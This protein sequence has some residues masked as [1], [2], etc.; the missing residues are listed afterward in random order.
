MQCTNFMCQFKKLV[1]KGLQELVSP[2]PAFACQAVT[3]QV[4]KSY[5]YP[6]NA[7]IIVY[8]WCLTF[9]IVCVNG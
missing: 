4:L 8:Y 1:Y 3:A 2:W 5:S 6:M 7:S 9:L